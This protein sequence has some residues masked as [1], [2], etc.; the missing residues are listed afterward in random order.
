MES[1][2]S[3]LKATLV[4]SILFGFLHGFLNLTRGTDVF[5]WMIA[6]GV[7]ATIFGFVFS[8]AYEITGKN[9]LLPIIIHG[10]WD[11]IIY[12]FKTVYNYHTIFNITA[13]IF[14]QVVAASVLIILLYL[15]KKYVFSF[16]PR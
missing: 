1:Q 5:Q 8:Y 14:S 13:E 15:L 9:L 6:V 12:Y 16:E 11:S 3:F 10:T 7:S 2:T 4:T